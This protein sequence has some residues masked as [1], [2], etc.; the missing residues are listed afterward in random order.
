MTYKCFVFFT[1]QTEQNW[2]NYSAIISLAVSVWTD[3]FSSLVDN[4]ACV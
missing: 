4:K 3:R 2:L 1:Q